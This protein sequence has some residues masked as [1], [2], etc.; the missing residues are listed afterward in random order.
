MEILTFHLLSAST[1]QAVVEN[2][3]LIAGVTTSLTLLT[4]VGKRKFF[5][6]LW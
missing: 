3:E 5:F 6:R 1:T 4:I 2:F